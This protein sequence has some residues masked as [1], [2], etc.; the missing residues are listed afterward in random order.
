MFLKIS[1]I[2]YHIYRSCN[3]PIQWLTRPHKINTTL[4]QNTCSDFQSIVTDYYD[5]R[6]DHSSPSY[7]QYQPNSSLWD[8]F[9][10]SDLCFSFDITVVYIISCYRTMLLWGL[11][12]LRVKL[13]KICSCGATAWKPSNFG[14][15]PS[16]TFIYV[17]MAEVM[18]AH[19]T[20]KLSPWGNPL[21]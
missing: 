1:V 20:D 3:D 9:N 7:T 16:P 13:I 5:Y 10:N 15:V 19:T 17:I 6:P 21:L 4:S 18:A 12:L 14:C 8:I 11:T 2:L